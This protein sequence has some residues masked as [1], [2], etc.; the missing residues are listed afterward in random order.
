MTIYLLF[1]ILSGTIVQL[2]H[3]LHRLF[4]IHNQ[5]RLF[6]SFIRRWLC[7]SLIC[8]ATSLLDWTV[9]ERQYFPIKRPYPASAP[10]ACNTEAFHCIALRIVKRTFRAVSIRMLG[11]K[12]I[13][14]SDDLFHILCS[15]HSIT[16]P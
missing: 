6:R 12:I 16:N 15:V 5:L 14:V 2:M 7:E 4:M 9:P 3:V 10:S 11:H 8:W 13:N 1:T